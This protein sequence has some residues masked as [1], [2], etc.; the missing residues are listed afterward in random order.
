[1]FWIRVLMVLS[2][3]IAWKK[4]ARSRRIVSMM[5]KRCLVELLV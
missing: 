1:M 5:D 3:R 2:S 4:A